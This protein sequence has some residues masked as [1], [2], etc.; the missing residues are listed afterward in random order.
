MKITVKDGV[1]LS[2][3]KKITDKK[4]IV[5]VQ[6]A[7][8]IAQ[9]NGL[10]VAE[11]FVK[12]HNGRTFVIDKQFK[13]IEEMKGDAAKPA[14]VRLAGTTRANGKYT[15]TDEDKK[16]IA[17]SLANRQMD[18][19]M[20]EDEKK[21]VMSSF[22]NRLNRIIADINLL[23]RKYLDGYEYRDFECHVEIDWAANTK[24]YIAV[25]GGSVIAVRAL[26]PSDYQLNLDIQ[27][28][29]VKKEKE[30]KEEKPCNK[31]DVVDNK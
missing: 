31:K 7:D 17:M 12:K 30:P 27:E 6:F 19:G 26:D 18:K 1:I 4:G 20:V 15:F 23:T 9:S 14:K 25:D 5:T 3:T 21:S 10:N 11:N 29:V 2:S 16:K 22:Q 28:A 24:S 8:I 13:I